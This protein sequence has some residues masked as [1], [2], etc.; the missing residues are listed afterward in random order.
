MGDTTLGVKVMGKGRSQGGEGWII[1]GLG[2]LIL[3]GLVYYSETGPGEENDSALIPNDLE[4]KIDFLVAA[5][6]T[7]FTKQWVDRGFNAIRSY[8]GQTH[9]TLLALVDVVIRVELESRQHSMT[10]YAKKQQAL[11]M[12]RRW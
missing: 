8:L 10:S 9:P 5:L 3:A 1:A 7:R 12:A 6:N 4:G 11:W 2:L